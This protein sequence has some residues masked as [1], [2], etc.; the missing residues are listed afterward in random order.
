[1]RSLFLGSSGSLS[2]DVFSLKF[3]KLFLSFSYATA[4]SSDTVSQSDPLFTNYL[5]NTFGFS[6]TRALS[7]SN[8]FSKSWVKN[9]QRIESTV[10]LLQKYGFSEA[11]IRHT[12]QIQPQILFSD[13]NKT[14]EPKL[15][16]FE[17]LGIT[18]SELGLYISMSTNVL[19]Q[20]LDRK[21]IPTIEILKRILSND[22]KAL[23]CVLKRCKWIL[24]KY[25]RLAANVSLLESY[26]IV[27]YQLSTLLKNQPFLFVMKESKIKDFLH[28]AEAMGFS[29]GSRMFV[30]GL[31]TSSSMNSETWEK[32][33]K[34]FQSFG[35][36]REDCA[37]MFRRTPALPRVSEEKLKIGIE[38]LISNVGIERSAIMNQPFVLMYSMEK[39][40]IPRYIVL[41]ILKSKK[42]LDKNPSFINVICLTEE[43]FLDK[44]IS[45][46]G[47]SAERLLVAYKGGDLLN[48]F[49]SEE[50]EGE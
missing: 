6:E 40:V 4:S 27:R 16:F 32:K 5:I 24:C 3:S 41:E 17:S 15:R 48:V 19:V 50:S 34:I 35:F 7:A 47:N 10:H 33:I 49:S 11:Q 9:P 45:R 28:K 37:V 30:H 21:M 1:M 36:S 2:R 39:R 14:L 18:G 42:L 29:P 26:G 44:Y 13:A 31:L 20:S 38:F 43:E 23:I 46:F 22:Q 8:R 25:P 12:I